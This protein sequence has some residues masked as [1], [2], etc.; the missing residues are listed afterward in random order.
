MAEPESCVSRSELSRGPSRAPDSASG[1]GG[2]GGAGPRSGDTGTDRAC[3]GRL[4][5]TAGP[6]GPVGLRAAGGVG[7]ALLSGG[8]LWGMRSQCNANVSLLKK[9]QIFSLR[10]K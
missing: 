8:R 5:V 2:A 4:W 9:H 6:S 7:P 10:L 1:E 3:V